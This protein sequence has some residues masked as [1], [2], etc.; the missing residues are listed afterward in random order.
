M[1]E[2][3]IECADCEGPQARPE[4]FATAVRI[5]GAHVEATHHDVSIERAGGEAA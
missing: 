4:Q 1:P 2:W 3:R 5:K